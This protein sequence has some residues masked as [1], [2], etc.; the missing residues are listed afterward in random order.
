LESK[1]WILNNEKTLQ[2]SHEIKTLSYAA[3]EVLRL[4]LPSDANIRSYACR[5][6]PNTLVFTKIEPAQLNELR[7]ICDELAQCGFSDTELQLIAERI[8]RFL[9]NSEE[10]SE[11]FDLK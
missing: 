1:Y 6:I 8:V 10:S 7:R 3:R 11:E 9:L 5:I 2:L 4:S